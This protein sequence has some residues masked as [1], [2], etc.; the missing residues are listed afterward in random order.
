MKKDVS[1]KIY[2]HPSRSKGDRH[3]LFIRLIYNRKKAEISTKHFVTLNEWDTDKERCKS[4]SL[5]NSELADIESAIR[6]IKQQL[7]YKNNPI[8]A[9]I[10][11]DIYSGKQKVDAY[12]LDKYESYQ[13]YVKASS[14]MAKS[15]ISTYE[16]TK[17][18]VADFVNESLKQPDILTSVINLEFIEKFDAFL[19]T[20][21]GQ[22]EDTLKRN[23]IG[24]HHSRFRTFLL[25][26]KKH[27]H[28]ETN[29]YEHFKIKYEESKRTYLTKEELT[30]FETQSLGGNKSLERVRDLFL[31]SVYTGLR[32]ADA[33]KLEMDDL[34]EEN[35]K[36]YFYHR[37]QK[38]RKHNRIPILPKAQKIIEKYADAPERSLGKVLPKISNQKCNTYLK[39]IAELACLTHKEV[40]HHVARHTCATTVLLEN[41]VPLETVKVWL[42]HSNI[43]ETMIYAKMTN[44]VISGAPSVQ[45]LYN[46]Y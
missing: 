14:T 18:L 7:T 35:G 41:Q 8:S 38:T 23:T 28:I 24:K 22:K 44:R 15:T 34:V 29:P 3:Q 45:N 33:Q 32:F 11:K 27:G 46:I 36:L 25:Y 10:L 12:L 43:R 6:T 13:E 37:E 39:V 21:P 16:K 17:N 40:T 26:L 4:N 2:P 30:A 19:K 20:R 9:R 5:I 31:F 1:I 42:N